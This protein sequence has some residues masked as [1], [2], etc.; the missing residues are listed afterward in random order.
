MT[1]QPCKNN[2]QKTLMTARSEANVKLEVKLEVSLEVEP[3]G[4]RE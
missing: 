3:K 1:K 4:A 2:L